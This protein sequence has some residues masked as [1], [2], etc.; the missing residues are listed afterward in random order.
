MTVGDGQAQS[1]QRAAVEIAHG[2][3][4]PFHGAQE[5]ALRAALARSSMAHIIGVVV[6]DTTSDIRMDDRQA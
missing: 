1:L 5:A 3:E 2:I 6:S 4:A